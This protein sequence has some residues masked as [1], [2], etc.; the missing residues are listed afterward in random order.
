MIIKTYIVGEKYIGIYHEK[1]FEQWLSITPTISTKRIIAS[2]RNWLN[3]G[4]T[5]TLRRHDLGH[6]Q[7]CD[8]I[9]PVNGFLIF[10]LLI[11][12]S[13]M[14]IQIQ[15]KTNTLNW[16]LIVLAHWN[17]SL[18]VDM[19]LLSDTLIPNQLVFACAP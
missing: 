2:Q 15:T 14:T 4:M 17:N 1:K 16:M 5:T 7:T 13:P 12:G 3:I 6:A 8:R 10:P 19:S 18:W 11:V 9:Q